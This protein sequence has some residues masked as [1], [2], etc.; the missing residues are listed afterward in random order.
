[1]VLSSVAFGLVGFWLDKKFDLLPWLFI[2]FTV[3]GFIGAAIS[4]YYRYQ[5]QM[6]QLAEDRKL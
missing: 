2:T 6:T 3:L 1:M 5:Y 4:I